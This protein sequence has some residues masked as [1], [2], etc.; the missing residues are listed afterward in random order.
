MSGGMSGTTVDERY[1]DTRQ[2]ASSAAHSGVISK[3][4]ITGF[5]DYPDRGEWSRWA[6]ARREAPIFHPDMEGIVVIAAW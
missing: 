5:A 6:R 4:A 2:R 1:V 3:V